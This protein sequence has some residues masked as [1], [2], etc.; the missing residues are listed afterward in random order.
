MKKL[1]LLLFL[2]VGLVGHRPM[3]PRVDPF[4]SPVYPGGA[5]EW[6]LD[7]GTGCQWYLHTVPEFDAEVWE[8]VECHN[9][10]DA[11]NW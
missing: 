4:C 9:G 2:F 5:G 7:E 11:G 1:F 6:L 8:C 10:T 3:E